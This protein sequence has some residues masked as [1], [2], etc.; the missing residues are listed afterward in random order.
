[1]A[2]WTEI[3]IG[4]N[5]GS[6]DLEKAHHTLLARSSRELHGKWLSVSEGSAILTTTSQII[7]RSRVAADWLRRR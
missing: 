1:M 5:A 4:C 6:T 2:V 7:S 3:F